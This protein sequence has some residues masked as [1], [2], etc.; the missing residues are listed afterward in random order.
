MKYGQRTNGYASLNIRV[1]KALPMSMRG[2]VVELSA[3]K[4]IGEHRHGG[5]ATDLM[6]QVCVEADLKDTF[7]MICVEPDDDCPLSMTELSNWY[8]RF[9]F[10]PIQTTPVVL[11]VRPYAGAFIR[12][13]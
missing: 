10:V 6:C 7:M 13:N 11:M 1:A 8:M 3:L 5:H 12:A 4:T 9:N 2:K